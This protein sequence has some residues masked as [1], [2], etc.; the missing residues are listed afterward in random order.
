MDTFLMLPR[1]D[2]EFKNPR[3]NLNCVQDYI[4]QPASKT[5]VFT[6]RDGSV[7]N[8]VL[9]NLKPEKIMKKLDSLFKIVK[10]KIT[11][12]DAV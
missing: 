10:F 1:S 4:F 9:H 2:E 7:R 12:A 8:L 11:K 6:L 5:I 3:L